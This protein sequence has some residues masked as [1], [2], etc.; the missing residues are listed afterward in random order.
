MGGRIEYEDKW[1]DNEALTWEPEENREMF[2]KGRKK[3]L[4]EFQARDEQLQ[5]LL[6]GKKPPVAK[7]AKRK[8]RRQ[9]CVM[10][11]KDGEESMG[12][13]VD[14]SEQMEDDGAVLFF[15]EGAEVGISTGVLMEKHSAH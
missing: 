7:R 2:G 3:I 6:S 15:W 4:E 11:V 14:E 10:E 12:F 9:A 8:R 5:H 13:G 1:E